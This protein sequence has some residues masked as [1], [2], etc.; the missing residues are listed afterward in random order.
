MSAD[1]DHYRVLEL[2][3]GSS[4]AEVKSQYR[5]LA[6]RYHPDLNGSDVQSQEKFRRVTTAYEFLS[7]PARKAAYDLRL[8]TFQPGPPP[9]AK[10]ASKPVPPTVPRPRGTRPPA[11]VPADRNPFAALADVKASRSVWFG[12]TALVVLILLGIGFCWENGVGEHEDHPGAAYAFSPNDTPSQLEPSADSPPTTV[13]P[14]M[15]LEAPDTSANIPAPVVK[16]K[17]PAVKPIVKSIPVNPP[18]RRKQN[19][20]IGSVPPASAPPM[21]PFNLPESRPSKIVLPIPIV[22]TRATIG[23][24]ELAKPL[25]ARYQA[26]VPQIDRLINQGYAVCDADQNDARTSQLKA[27]LAQLNAVRDRVRPAIA[28][29]PHRAD[30]EELR[31]EVGPI[32]ADLRQLEAHPQPVRQDIQAL[33]SASATATIPSEPQ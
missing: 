28:H 12:G 27:D 8:S 19:F 21:P 13:P 24:R 6:K 22:E 1:G 9:K 30:A 15:G 4:M 32:L 26:I 31:R 17:L 5:Q 29:L 18:K 25:L 16:P 7:D 14:D 23:T 20:V 10:T 3:P 11:Y 2:K 33:A